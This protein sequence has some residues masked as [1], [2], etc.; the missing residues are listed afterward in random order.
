MNKKDCRFKCEF[1]NKFYSSTN[2]LWNHNKKFHKTN[3]NIIQTN[4]NIIQTNDNIIQTNDNKNEIKSKQSIN[5]KYCK[6]E[7][8]HRN[9]RWKHEQSCKTKIIHEP[10]KIELLEMKIKEL[11]NKINNNKI[12][13][14]N[15]NNTTNNGII[16]NV[17]INQV[18]NENIHKLS[19]KEIK[20][21]IK[22]DNYLIDIIKLLNFNDKYPENHNF[23]NTSL[24]GK[25]ISVFNSDTNK[26]EKINKNDFYDKVLSNSF[27][28]M[29]N[30]SLV[31]ELNNDIREQIKEK[32]RN[33]L[34]NK[35]THIKDIFYK[36]KLYKKNYKT[37][38]NELSY[39]KN[40][41]VLDTWATVPDVEIQD[42]ESSD[43]EESINTKYSAFT[44]DSSDTE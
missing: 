29:D 18:G 6:K 3:D 17:T 39:N 5:C 31:L 37:N 13:T 41:V 16:N 14:K 2:S 36:D 33:H 22:N 12:I 38:I 23:C 30:L 19:I 20:E 9:S 15:N 4:D 28:K 43:S 11:E 44:S 32:Y 40:K 34:D 1:C 27:I 24:E 7:F 21:L 26:I 25:Y 35:L 8:S 42:N 10:N